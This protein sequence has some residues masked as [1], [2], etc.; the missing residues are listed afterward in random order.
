MYDLLLA[1]LHRILSKLFFL[2]SK[3]FFSFL[4]YRVKYKHFHKIRPLSSS[5]S[6][7]RSNSTMEL[8]KTVVSTLDSC[9]C[10]SKCIYFN[11]EWPALQRVKRR[12]PG[13]FSIWI[14]VQVPAGFC[15]LVL[16]KAQWSKNAV[17]ILRVLW[18]RTG[19]GKKII[20]LRTRKK[21]WKVK[22]E[23]SSSILPTAHNQHHS[24]SLSCI[25]VTLKVISCTRKKGNTEEV[26]LQ[27]TPLSSCSPCPPKLHVASRIQTILLA[28][29]LP[30]RGP[31][32]HPFLP[33][34]I[35][36]IIIY[37]NTQLTRADLVSQ[38]LI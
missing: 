10:F 23:N 27:H 11:I 26:V 20:L 21:C 32:V 18:R 12:K 38:F 19:K 3:S 34:R 13:Q 8:Y 2:L 31:T 30:G 15:S 16:S 5:Y 7:N 1:L 14:S 28:E 33:L 36:L 24:Q 4:F 25:M 29:A 6:L 9:F 17:S 35:Y 22:E 37:S